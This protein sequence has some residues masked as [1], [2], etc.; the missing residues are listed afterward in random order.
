MILFTLCT[1]ARGEGVSSLGVMTAMY[2]NTSSTEWPWLVW[3]FPCTASCSFDPKH[4]D[5]W[6]GVDS[7]VS[8]PVHPWGVACFLVCECQTEPVILS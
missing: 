3:F 4:S 7:L 5:A 6:T 8:H 2:G 1:V